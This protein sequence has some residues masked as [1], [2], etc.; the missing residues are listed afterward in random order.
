LSI[1]GIDTP[2][3]NPKTSLRGVPTPTRSAVVVATGSSAANLS[4]SASTQKLRYSRR[5]LDW[6]RRTFSYHAN[7][8]QDHTF[9]I[10]HGKSVTAQISAQRQQLN[11]SSLYGCA[12]RT[13]C[14]Y[15]KASDDPGS[16]YSLL[17]QAYVATVVNQTRKEIP[18]L[19]IG[20]TGGVRFDL[21]QGPFTYDDS[22]ITIPFTNTFQ[23]LPDIDYQ[24]ASVSTL[25]SLLFNAKMKSELIPSSKY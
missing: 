1:D 6:N 2:G 23:F 5:Y 25:P 13:Y 20:N 7:G 15:C 14:Q 16:I 19:I 24:L 18:R 3:Y 11:L 9:E 8:S 4:L 22:F 17:P 21:V 12:P 10:Q